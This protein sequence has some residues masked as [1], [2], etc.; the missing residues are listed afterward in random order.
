VQLER[1]L[2]SKLNLTWSLFFLLLG[3]INLY[4]ARNFSEAFWVDFK[5][6]GVIGLTIVFAVA[7]GLWLASKA[8]PDEPSKPSP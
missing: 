4:V 5:L 3:A 6:F 1:D 2:W 8:P 7:Q